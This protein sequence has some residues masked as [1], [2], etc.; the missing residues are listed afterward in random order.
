MGTSL[1]TSHGD[2]G[3]HA[4]YP[5][6]ARGIDSSAS[7]IAAGPISAPMIAALELGVEAHQACLT[8][9]DGLR[10]TGLFTLPTNTKAAARH[11]GAA[12]RRR[13]RRI[14]PLPDVF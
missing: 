8:G 13:L 12:P 1:T 10:I 4:G 3:D 9:V 2:L 6:A 14:L 11:P 7:K 5:A